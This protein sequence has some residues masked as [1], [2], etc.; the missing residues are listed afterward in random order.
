VADIS[1]VTAYLYQ[2]VINIVYPNG[3]SSP[4][5]AP[6]PVGFSNPADVLI[7]EGW[8][9]PEQLDLDLAG[10]VEAGNPPKPVPRTN[11]PR[12]NVSIFPTGASASSTYQILDKTYV[13][14]EP[15]FGLTVEV[16]GNSI[17]ITGTPNAGEFVTIIADREY[18]F[19]EGGS[20]AAA[21]L[22]A[23]LTAAQ[24]DYPNASLSGS[25]L[26]VPYNFQLDVR[27]GGVG[28][29]GKVTHRQC[30]L[31]MVTVWAPDHNTRSVLAKAIDAALKS[32]IVVTMPD[33]SDAK[34]VYART[35][36]SDE[37]QNVTAYRR[38]LIYE[39]DYAT[40][41]TF[42]GTTITSVQT[43][44]TASGDPT[45]PVTPPVVDLVT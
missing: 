1:D 4:S 12:A 10:E 40:L 7:V 28:L 22:S 5:I 18:I 45:G 3:T 44:I 13:L 29:L 21:V 43:K 39:V 30:Q 37:T 19:S 11:G 36:V 33:S 8:P 27:Q 9:I 14:Q 16:S 26:T 41:E 34:I 25:T 31:V 15:T 6:V 32:Q 23:L 38:D 17:T 35:N 42:P 24:V 2:A 20:T